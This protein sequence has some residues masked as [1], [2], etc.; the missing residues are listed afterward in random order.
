MRYATLALMT[1]GPDA[2]LVLLLIVCAWGIGGLRRR[3]GGSLM[4]RGV[5]VVGCLGLLV[6]MPATMALAADLVPEAAS[7][8]KWTVELGMEVRSLPHYQGSEVSA[9][10]QVPFLDV[11]RAGT[12]PRF[13]APRDGFGYAILDTDTFKAGPVAQVELGRRVRHNPQLAGL[14]NVGTP[15]EVGG[16][17]DYWPTPWVRVRVEVRQGFGGHHGIVSDQT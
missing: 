10:H 4:G 7:A 14:G 17:F 9:F 5:R 12:P 1:A 6:A 2:F 11:R 15:A 3:P 13:H 16:F 8:P